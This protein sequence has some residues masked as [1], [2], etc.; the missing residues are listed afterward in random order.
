MSKTRRLSI[1]C[2]FSALIATISFCAVSFVGKTAYA[3]SERIQIFRDTFSEDEIDDFKWNVVKGGDSVIEQGGISNEGAIVMKSS[4]S[5]NVIKMKDTIRLAA[6]EKLEMT[7]TVDNAKGLFVMPSFNPADYYEN[8]EVANPFGGLRFFVQTGLSVNNVFWN[9]KPDIIAPHMWWQPYALKGADNTGDGYDAYIGQNSAYDESLPMGSP[10]SAS[11]THIGDDG[12]TYSTP[13]MFRAV[14]H[15]D[16]SIYYYIKQTTD[17]EWATLCIV[18][19]GVKVL[20][21]GYDDVGYIQS[22][23]GKITTPDDPA[24]DQANGDWTT[25]GGPVMQGVDAVAAISL[26]NVLDQH[27]LSVR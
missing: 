11:D 10:W 20:A 18:K 5:W 19:S 7:F 9:H 23:A 6:G 24:Y 8:G 17:A 13:V 25:T 15:A 12:W 3:G 22:N 27:N 4:T 2:F 1:I 26:V 21:H 14:Y 16:G